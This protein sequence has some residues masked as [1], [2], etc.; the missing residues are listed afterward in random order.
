MLGQG[1]EAAMVQSLTWCQHVG[2][3][4]FPNIWGTSTNLC[5]GLIPFCFVV[6]ETN[7]TYLTQLIS[8]EINSVHTKR[9]QWTEQ[10][11]YG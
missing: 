1:M 8:A 11:W 4:S 9:L 5:T 10:L 3:K 2:R 6:I 7:A